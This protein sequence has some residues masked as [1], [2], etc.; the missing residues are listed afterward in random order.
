M[1]LSSYLEGRWQPGEGTPFELSDPTTGAPLARILSGGLDAQDALDFARDTGG[2]A[3]RDLTFAERGRLLAAVAARLGAAR[4]V[5]YRTALANSGSNRAD[6]AL[7]IEGAIQT[8]QYYAGL[9]DRLGDARLLIEPGSDQ[10]TRDP[11]FSAAHLWVP[12]HGAAILVNAFNFPAWGLWGKAAVALLSGVPVVAK[13]ASSTAML[14][15]EMVRE[16]AG[17]LPQGAVSLYLGS[18]RDLLRGVGPQDAVAFTGSADTAD[19]IRAHPRVLEMQPRVNVEADS[20]NASILG[21]DVV[22]SGKLFGTF[23]R[24]MAREITVKAG[25]KCTTARRLIVP[26]HLADE[27]AQAL[28]AELARVVMGNPRRG[29][30][31]LGPLV[32]KMQ[33]DAVETAIGKLSGAARIIHRGDATPLDADPAI[34]AFVPLHLLRAETAEC[35]IVN[36]IEAFGPCATLIP[37]DGLDEAFAVARRGGGSL[38]CSLFTDDAAAAARA[39][40]GLASHHGRILLVDDTIADAHTDH[41]IVMPHCVH[42]GPGRAGGG[43]ELGGLRGMR[44]HH[45]R[46]AMQAST[47]GL[48]RLRTQAREVAF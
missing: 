22:P 7:D 21:P 24:E 16:V 30:V 34:G 39:A 48:A 41:S 11:R 20:V 23:V 9:G 44:L 19:Q 28:C 3:L 46:T 1:L 40:G 5:W 33:Q 2:A 18:G 6:A 14:A 13:P 43:E 47:E 45:Q 25:Q 32:T 29:D 8:L 42:G 17:I 4:D 38:A 26:R 31:T 36:E 37:C 10:L 35:G 12:H 27:V 15:W